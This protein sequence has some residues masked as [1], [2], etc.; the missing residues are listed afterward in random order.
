MKINLINM[1]QNM[2]SNNKKKYDEPITIIRKH[3]LR[4][5]Y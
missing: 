3:I 4:Y 2:L 1:S 5:I